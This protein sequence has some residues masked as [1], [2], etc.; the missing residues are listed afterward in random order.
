MKLP[1][2][3]NAYVAPEKLSD[4][5]LSEAHDEGGPKSK[6]FRGV[7]FA[8]AM[9]DSLSQSLKAIASGFEVLSETPTEHGMKY[10]VD[11]S[12]LSPTGQTVRV[13]TVWMVRTEEDFPRFV[14]AYPSKKTRPAEVER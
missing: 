7:G 2:A 4:Y 14:T 12:L 5:L 6:F 3:E 11:G 9:A 13:R 10:V 8:E 1:N